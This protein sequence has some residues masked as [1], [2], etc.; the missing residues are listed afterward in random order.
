M[1][2][3]VLSDGDMTRQGGASASV[4]AGILV[5]YLVREGISRLLI[6]RFSDFLRFAPVGYSDFLSPH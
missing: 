3:H 5:R 2:R 1:V 6:H 4:S